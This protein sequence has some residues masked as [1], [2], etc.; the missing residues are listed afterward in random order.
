VPAGAERGAVACEDV[1]VDVGVAGPRERQVDVGGGV[2][3]LD[4]VHVP[5]TH[6]HAGG[7]G[8]VFAQR[9][10]G[11]SRVVGVVVRAHVVGDDADLHGSAAEG[12]LAAAASVGA[13][14]V[15]AASRLQVH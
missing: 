13:V 3:E 11:G 15:G 9:G 6:A 4:G 14:L 2:L 5:P 10:R 7:R 1:E 8:R 12:L